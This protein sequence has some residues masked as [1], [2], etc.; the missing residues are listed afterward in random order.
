MIVEQHEL[1]LA[2]FVLVVGSGGTVD[3]VRQTGCCEP[4]VCD[5]CRG[6]YNTIQPRD[7]RPDCVSWNRSR[8]QQQLGRVTVSSSHSVLSSTALSRCLPMCSQ[9]IISDERFRA[10]QKEPAHRLIQLK[11]RP[12]AIADQAYASILYGRH[13][14]MAMRLLEQKLR[15]PEW[16]PRSA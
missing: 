13:I 16:Q 2:D 6:H 9:S 3:P 14:R 1:P 5:A 10:D 12:T 7:S 8:H 11:D 4:H 15:L